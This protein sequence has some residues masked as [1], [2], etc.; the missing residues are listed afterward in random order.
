MSTTATIRTQTPDA[1]QQV[2]AIIGLRDDLEA[3]L[4]QQPHQPLAKQQRVIRNDDAHDYATA[5]SALNAATERSCLA[6]NP[7]TGASASRAP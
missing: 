4:G 3:L 5:T 2:I 1:P 6:M 7:C